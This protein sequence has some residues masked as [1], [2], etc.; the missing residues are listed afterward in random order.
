MKLL[1]ALIARAFWRRYHYLVRFGWQQVRGGGALPM[2]AG[3]GV[4]VFGYLLTRRG[5]VA[6]Q[7]VYRYS[8]ATGESVRIR[9]TQGNRV[10]A[11]R[12]ITG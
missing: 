7:R 1:T 4:L 6:N 9:M 2:S 5:R 3:W 10:L 8:L 11:D 12:T